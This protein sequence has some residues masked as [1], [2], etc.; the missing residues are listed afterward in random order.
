MHTPCTICLAKAVKNRGWKPVMPCLPIPLA[1]L[2]TDSLEK[3]N[4]S[5]KSLCSSRSNFHYVFC[6]ML[7]CPLAPKP[8]GQQEHQRTLKWGRRV[9]LGYLFFNLPPPTCPC[10]P[11]HFNERKKEKLAKIQILVFVLTFVLRFIYFP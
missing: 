10:L 2:S 4:L 9:M 1:P 5:W 3:E 6:L 8:A 7:S 11:Y